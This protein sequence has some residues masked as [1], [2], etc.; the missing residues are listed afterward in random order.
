MKIIS[1]EKLKAEEFSE[2][3]T[4]IWQKNKQ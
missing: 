1:K 2:R 4:N 3:R